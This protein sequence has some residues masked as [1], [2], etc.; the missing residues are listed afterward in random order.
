[1]KIYEEEPTNVLWLAWV[2]IPILIL[3]AVLS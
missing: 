1:M 2:A 3:L